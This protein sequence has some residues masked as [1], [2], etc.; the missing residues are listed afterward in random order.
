[1]LKFFSQS[2]GQTDKHQ[3]FEKYTVCHF[4]ARQAITSKVNVKTYKFSYMQNRH[5]SSERGKILKDVPFYQS[6]HYD[7][8]YLM[9]NRWMNCKRSCRCAPRERRETR[10]CKTPMLVSLHA[11]SLFNRQICNWLRRTS[12]SSSRPNKPSWKCRNSWFEIHFFS[13]NHFITYLWT[14][15]ILSILNQFVL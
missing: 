12:N 2:R 13:Q 4:D 15:N 11:R 1:M 5:F 3:E 9:W 8:K 7:L 10:D 14:F 6:K